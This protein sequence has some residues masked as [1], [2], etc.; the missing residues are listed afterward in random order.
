[1]IILWQITKMLLIVSTSIAS[2]QDKSFLFTFSAPWKIEIWKKEQT[3]QILLSIEQK[4]NTDLNMYTDV[5]IWKIF[6]CVSAIQSV[7]YV[8][9]ND[10]IFISGLFQ[11]PV[12]PQPLLLYTTIYIE[13]NNSKFHL[14]LYLICLYFLCIISTKKS[15]KFKYIDIYNTRNVNV[16]KIRRWFGRQKTTYKTTGKLFHVVQPISF[17]FLFVL[18]YLL[19][20]Y[21][22]QIESR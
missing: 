22:D 18:T 9:I 11:F 4:K 8:W 14:K 17:D 3:F 20:E 1:M 2:N 13:W 19:H 6:F 7:L 5:L 15:C 21:W 16:H 12:L 10:K